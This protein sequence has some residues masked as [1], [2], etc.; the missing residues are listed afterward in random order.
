MAVL[1]RR[2]RRKKHRLSRL[3]LL[4]GSMQIVLRTPLVK[5]C[6][7]LISLLVV[8]AYMAIAARD[9]IAFHVGASPERH[10]MEEAMALEPSNAEYRHDFGSYLMF[11]ERRPDLAVPYYRS[12]AALKGYSAEYWV[13]LARAYAAIGDNNHQELALK[14][15]LR[16]DPN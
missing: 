1:R 11:N 5:L 2:M 7:K 12:A 4:V 6:L 9:Y 16:V 13:D 3:N 15:A 14:Q 8:T 10:A